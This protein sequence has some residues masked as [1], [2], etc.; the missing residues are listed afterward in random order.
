MVDVLKGTHTLLSF[1]IEQE[2]PTAPVHKR[3]IDAAIKAG[4]K[5]FAPSEWS[6]YVTKEVVLPSGKLI[7]CRSKF[8]H[9]DWYAYKNTTRAYL[10]EINKN[11]KVLEYTL[12]HPGLFLNY[13]TYPHLSMT[14]VSKLQ[15]PFDFSARRFLMIEGGESARITLTA[16]HDLVN[17]VTRAVD[18]TGEWPVTGG[19]CGTN[20]SIKDLHALAEK[21][22]GGSVDVTL[23]REEDLEAGKWTAPWCPRADHPSIPKDQV[24]AISAWMSG[25]ILLAMTAGSFE[26][27]GVW[28]R[29]LPDYEFTGAEEFL[30]KAWEGKP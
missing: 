20:V 10:A 27:E 16:I 12:F 6:S 4:V 19:I 23:L 14:H 1:V 5:R 17:V 30:S 21:I 24:E 7:D 11:Q 28:N 29:L 26:V 18:Y 3:L 15:V 2:D 25:K 8:D 22:R 13:L 9:L